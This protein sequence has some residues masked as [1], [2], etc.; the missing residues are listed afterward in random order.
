[1]S[2]H[3]Q[4]PLVEQADGKHLRLLIVEDVADDVELILRAIKRDGYTIEYET[5]RNFEEISPLLTAA[6]WDAI[7]V[8]YDL[9]EGLTGED[10]LT[11]LQETGLDIP[12]IMVSG[13]IPEETG[14]NMMRLGAHDFVRKDN[15]YRLAPAIE[16]EIAEAQVR[17]RR[18]EAEER[19]SKA[20][21]ANPSA[22]CVIQLDDLRFVDV[23]QHFA[24][25]L[26]YRREE[27]IDR[28]VHDL[29]LWDNIDEGT[30]LG[31]VVGRQSVVRDLETRI[32][33]RDGSYCDVLSSMDVIDLDGEPH[34]LAMF[35]DITERKTLERERV[36]LLEREKAARAAAEEANVMKSEFLAMISHELRTPLTSIKG[37]TSTLLA[38]D[39]DWDDRERDEFIE[40]IDLESEKLLDMVKQLLDVSRIQ[41]KML[42][43]E[44]YPIPPIEIVRVAEAQLNGITG[45]HHLEIDV[46]L[47]LPE[48]EADSKRIAQ[49]ITNLVHNAT[50]FS[51]RGTRIRLD[52]AADGGGQVRFSVSDEGPG[53]PPA[54]RERV[55]Q[56][57]QQ[58]DDLRV[59]SQAG[60]GVGL[61]ICKGLVEAHGGRIWIEDADTPGAVLSFTV[62]TA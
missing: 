25:L 46:P 32:Q 9:G 27:I 6:P 22:L 12:F 59:G 37:F 29:R 40:I 36:E 16:R 57:F 31:R 60:T 21:L 50:K 38:E 39:V 3:H 11:R 4:T 23:N 14:V 2:T 7:L 45:D 15:L 55:F 13:V 62:P 5:A 41:A 54:Q 48:V 44:S 35:V 58:A 51:P 30:I 33:H 24:D 20:F 10:V 18:R 1:M 61:A 19:F 34:L 52:A 43:I 42:R 53:I 26:G 17:Q 28:T 49:V 8:D 56:M 47:D